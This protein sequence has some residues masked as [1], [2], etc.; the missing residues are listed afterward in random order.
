MNTPSP[1]DEV[2]KYAPRW[3]REGTEK[4]GDAVSLADAAELAV[5]QDELPWY[6][7]FDDQ[8]P[9][10]QELE[11]PA[12]TR[13]D[14]VTIGPV[15]GPLKRVG[16]VSFAL[17]AAM[18]LALTLDSTL[19]GFGST[20]EDAVAITADDAPTAETAIIQTVETTPATEVA[21][22][23]DSTAFAPA[24]TNA[25]YVAAD[26]NPATSPQTQQDPQPTPEPQVQPVRQMRQAPVQVSVARTL[27]PEEVDQLINRGR[28]FLAQGDVVAARLFLRRAAEAGDARATLMLGG[29]YDPAALGKL[30]VVG[31]RSDP[32][33]A[34]SWYARAAELGSREAS[35]RL[36]G[37]APST[38]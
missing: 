22:T 25:A 2:S 20:S 38:R 16:D 11:E 30:G 31:I 26:P 8:V 7:P 32:Q 37:L 12:L 35:Q 4:P 33:Q 17:I 18:A 5:D 19:T 3:V 29:T 14:L 13:F 1:P 9:D 34:Q 10:A 24:I 21:Q 23:I 36:A 28:A 6:G 15:N 27:D